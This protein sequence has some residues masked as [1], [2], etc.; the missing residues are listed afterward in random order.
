MDDL[1]MQPRQDAKVAL[2]CAWLGKWLDWLG[3]MEAEGWLTVA[4]LR[5]S[6]TVDQT[7]RPLIGERQD[8][9]WFL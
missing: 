8:L 9:V 2:V 3:G 7:V 4:L 5:T 6:S 1:L